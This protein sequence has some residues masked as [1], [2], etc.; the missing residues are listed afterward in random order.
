MH[1]GIG[2]DLTTSPG[3]VEAETWPARHRVHKYWGRKPANV[4]AR[5]VEHFTRRGDVVLD[6][7][8]GSGV[9]P[10]EAALLGRRGLGVDNNPVAIE[11]AR[12][13]VEPVC[14][15]A[16]TTRTRA[17]V[18][19]LRLR[20]GDRYR[21]LC[22]GCGRDAV[23][24]SFGWRSSRLTR[25]RYLCVGCGRRDDLASAAD[26]ALAA[27][28]VDAAGAPDA[29][30]HPG[31]QMRKLVRAEL[32]RWSEL[33]T[34]RNLAVA[35]A[36]REAI[37]AI[38]EP[39]L[40]R[41]LAI[42]LSSSLAQLSRMIADFSGRAGGP[43]WKLNSYWLPERWQELEPLRYFENRVARSAAA[44]R[45]LHPRARELAAARVHCADSRALALPSRSVDYIFTDP[46][47]GGEGIQY[48][49]LSMLWALW[50]G[51]D[52][53]LETEVAFNPPRG[54]DH[55]HY[56]RGL[57]QCMAEAARVLKPNGWMT[58][59]FAN[60]DPEVWDA[61]MQGC[62]R[63][64]L[65]L[66]SAAPM[67]RSAPGLTEATMHRAP[68]TDLVLGLRHARRR[69][70][71][72]ARPAPYALA[73]RARAIATQLA[74]R[75]QPAT[76]HAVHDRVLIDWLTRA[77]ADG[78]VPAGARPSLDAVEAALAPGASTPGTPAR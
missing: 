27:E 32:A 10:V 61:L 60:K 7:F 46:P 62:A 24:R 22:R 8:C 51:V 49:E 19:E 63:A 41:W 47:Y 20:F 53:R 58:V 72:P 76:A 42:T 64:G 33:F 74:G 30:I 18:A 50:L 77:C 17:I 54:F 1:S 68:K 78:A 40:R 29:S 21:T 57:A 14:P 26:R 38:P 13:L 11:L 23:V 12:S 15:D 39:P 55:A 4:V 66:V 2:G 44:L 67:K 69:A 43:S 9:T 16:F 5:Y 37:L 56:A 73:E 59:T 65:E 25:V 45:E 6:P 52:S 36:L 34:P 48:G 28:P 31:W 75:G 3:V 35:A 70:R 71:R